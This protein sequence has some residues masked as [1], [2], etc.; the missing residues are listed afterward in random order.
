MVRRLCSDLVLNSFAESTPSIL[1]FS[2]GPPACRIRTTNI[3]GGASLALLP[4]EVTLTRAIISPLFTRCELSTEVSRSFR[5][6][7]CV[8]ASSALRL[9]FS[10]SAID[11]SDASIPAVEVAEGGAKRSR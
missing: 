4:G 11:F 6:V 10:D 1:V 8:T 3:D 9:C 2:V 5:L 7:C